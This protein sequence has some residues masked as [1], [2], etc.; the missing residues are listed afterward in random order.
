LLCNSICL[1][2]LKGAKLEGVVTTLL[3]LVDHVY[4]NCNLYT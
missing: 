3:R 1:P 4:Y 2:Q